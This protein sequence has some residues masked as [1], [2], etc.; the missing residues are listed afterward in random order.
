LKT[1]VLIKE[2]QRNQTYFQKQREAGEGNK[3]LRAAAAHS[4]ARSA[5]ELTVLIPL[6]SI[7]FG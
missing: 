5:F 3:A 6:R 1:A 2:N 7:E 4:S